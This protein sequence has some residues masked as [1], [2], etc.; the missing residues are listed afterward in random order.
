MR[1]A[2][3]CVGRARGAPFADDIAHYERL[4]SRHAR[5]ETVELREAGASA[6]GASEAV[7]REGETILSRLPADAHV[8]VLD[9][10]GDQHTSEGFAAW[11]ESRRHEGRDLWFAVG[12]PFGI[13]ASVI[14]RADSRLSLGPLTLPHQLARVVLMEQLF[15]AH[16][17]LGR[18]PY[19]Y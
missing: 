4:L 14:E 2:L 7:R 6:D 19:H 13:A 8:C 15:R 9:R 1:I 16:K 10:E 18:E 5:L 11:L 12:G 3:L 17:I